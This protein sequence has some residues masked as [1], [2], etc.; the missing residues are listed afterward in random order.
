VARK[1]SRNPDPAVGGKDGQQEQRGFICWESFFNIK[2]NHHQQQKKITL[3][4]IALK[5]PRLGTDLGAFLSVA[6]EPDPALSG[7][8]PATAHRTEL[9]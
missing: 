2:T 8:V 6:D 3:L 5:K 1:S 9:G 7:A 4:Q